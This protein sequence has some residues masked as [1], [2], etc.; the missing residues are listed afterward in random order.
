MI[1]A[2]ISIVT[3]G[4]HDMAQMRAFYRSLGW[5][6]QD[7]ASDE[8]SMFHTAGGVLS[9]F[10]IEDLAKDANV[11]ATEPSN[12]RAI[13]LAINLESREQVDEAFVALRDLGATITKAPEEVFW[14][15]YSGYFADP[16]G[17]LWEIA[18]NPFV[19]F[20]ERGALIIGE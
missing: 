6:E 17:N 14:G 10:G 19:N 13:A 20:D 11:P 18:W 2:R 9:L 1:P 8:H 7:G 5:S 3:L 15:G 4:A 12:Y 16:E